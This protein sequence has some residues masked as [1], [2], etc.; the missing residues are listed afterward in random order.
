MGKTTDFQP[1][2]GITLGSGLASFADA[3]EKEAD[4]QFS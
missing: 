2:Y 1:E 3:M 4:F